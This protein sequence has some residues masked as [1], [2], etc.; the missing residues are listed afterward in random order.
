LHTG[1][2]VFPSRLLKLLKNPEYTEDEVIPGLY[3]YAPARSGQCVYGGDT[4]A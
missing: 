4:A 2:P 3:I 1:K